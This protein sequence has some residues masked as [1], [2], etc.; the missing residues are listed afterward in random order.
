MRIGRKDYQAF[1]RELAKT[2]WARASRE[3]RS[4]AAGHESQI[5][6]RRFAQWRAGHAEEAEAAAALARALRC[7][8]RKRTSDDDLVGRLERRLERAVESGS[9]LL[10]WGKGPAPAD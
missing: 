1:F 3:E 2:R 8:G 7:L 6:W 5:K 9:K 10:P 4:A